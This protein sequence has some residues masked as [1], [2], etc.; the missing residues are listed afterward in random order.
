MNMWTSKKLLKV[1]K[2]Y[3]RKTEEK[4]EIFENKFGKVRNWKNVWL[5][6]LNESIW[7]AKLYLT[8][9]YQKLD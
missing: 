3:N 5:K 1:S 6:K 9:G 4:N 7:M 2:L 8:I